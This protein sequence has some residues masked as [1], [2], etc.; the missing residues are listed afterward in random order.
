MTAEDRFVRVCKRHRLPLDGLTCPHGR[1][2]HTEKWEVVDRQ[3]GTAI[4]HADMDKGGD[5]YPPGKDR[6]MSDEKKAKKGSNEKVL[7][8]KSYTDAAGARLYL[9]IVQREAKTPPYAIRW[10]RSERGND[11]KV[12]TKRGWATEAESLIKARAAF[13][14]TVAS[15]ERD[16]W[17]EAERRAFGKAFSLTPIPAASGT[18]ARRRA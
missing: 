10:H 8:S 2:H 15:V 18:P 12:K 5:F 13:V 4:A 7:E 6:P 17:K 11:G 9:T 16:G 1:G 14:T 3:K